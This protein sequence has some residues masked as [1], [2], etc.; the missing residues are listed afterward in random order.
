MG[1]PNSQQQGDRQ[2]SGNRPAETFAYPTQGGRIEVSI[3][4]NVHDDEG[5]ERVSYSVTLR[6]SYFDSQDQKW[7]RSNSLFLQDLLPAA[8]G[9]RQAFQ[10][11]VNEQ[12]RK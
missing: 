2:E 6:R 1:F 11:I 4:E 8:E 9:L 7:K 3:W 10:L 12:S 5:G